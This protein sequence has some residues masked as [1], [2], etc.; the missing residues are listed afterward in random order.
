[1]TAV[2]RTLRYLGRQGLAVR[3]KRNEDLSK[4]DLINEGK[5]TC[6]GNSFYITG[7]LIWTTVLTVYGML[8][9]A[10]LTVKLPKFDMSRISIGE[11]IAFVVHLFVSF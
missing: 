1:M 7:D 4:E 3:G 9:L 8:L 5:Y 11:F 10:I 6:E 2:L